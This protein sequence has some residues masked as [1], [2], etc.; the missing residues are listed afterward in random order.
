MKTIHY[1]LLAVL[2]SAALISCHSCQ[3]PAAEE[4]AT[5]EPSQP[6]DPSRP[7]DP[8]QPEEPVTPDDPGQPEEPVTPEEPELP[9]RPTAGLY[10]F[11]LPKTSSKTAWVEGDQILV[12]GYY[13]AQMITVTLKAEEIAEDGRTAQ[14]QLDAVP[15]AL[16]SPDWLYAAYPADAVEYTGNTAEN[17]NRFVRTDEELLVAYWTPENNTFAFR[18]VTNCIAFTVSGDYDGYILASNTRESLSCDVF[19]VQYSSEV[20]QYSKMAEDGERFLHREVVADGQTVNRLY[21]PVPIQ[22][23][24][25][26]TIFLKKGDTYPMA[27]KYPNKIPSK[28]GTVLDL[29]DITSGLEV[30]GG[31]EPKMPENMPTMGKHTRINVNGVPEFSGMCLSKDKDFL[32]MVGDEGNLA[33]FSFDGETTPWKRLGG[34]LEGVTLNPATGDLYMCMEGDQRVAVV[35][36]PETDDPSKLKLEKVFD[37]QEARDGKYGNSGT[38]GITWYKDDLIYVGT[39]TGANLWCY[40][41]SG[42]VQYFVS[43]RT[44]ADGI[45]EIA[46]LSY[47]PV[48][49]WLWVVD[50]ERHRIFV[51]DGAATTM[52][53]RYKLKTVGNEESICVDHGN[54]CVWIGDD[55][56]SQPYITKYEFE[57]LNP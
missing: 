41:L 23:S 3:R 33:K 57:G 2:A 46:G 35:R 1:L 13:T 18:M 14:V 5:E 31:P 26:F 51:F 6:E 39:Q 4:P 44:I 47:D 37:V 28:K 40:N 30:Y 32:W 11:V 22:F 20:A 29:G 15:E 54:N 17:V 42:E 36:N 9:S 56:D 16:C 50:S 45:F 55:D 24:Y 8:G 21:L 25:G 49:D 27:F 38:E 52:L 12:H 10:T 34:D 48:N 19:E 53:A 7:E 43:L